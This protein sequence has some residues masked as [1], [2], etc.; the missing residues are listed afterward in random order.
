MKLPSSARSNCAASCPAAAPCVVGHSAPSRFPSATAASMRRPDTPNRSVATFDTAIWPASQICPMR[1][2]ARSL[3]RAGAP[4][5]GSDRADPLCCG[6][7]S[8]YPSDRCSPDSGARRW[9]S[10]RSILRPASALTCCGLTST[11]RAIA[12]SS[13]FQTA[14]QYCPVDSITTSETCCLLSH[15]RN[16]RRSRKNLDT[17]VP[18]ACPESALSAAI[19][20]PECSSCAR[21]CRSNSDTILTYKHLS[22]PKEG[23]RVIF[24]R[25]SYSCSSAR[26]RTPQS[27]IPTNMSRLY[28]QSRSTSS[29]RI[30]APDSLGASF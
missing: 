13:T 9:L 27:M 4:E 25:Q 19:C 6:L 23:H 30:P 26:W 16:R 2:F 20:A 1:F 15:P 14:R 10:I 11:K 12:P 17:L 21:R 28:S 18:V 3:P 22:P 24:Q 29:K 5:S 7:A 8:N